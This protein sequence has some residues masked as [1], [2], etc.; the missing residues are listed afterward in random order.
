MTA[1]PKIVVSV[2]DP[3]LRDF[4]S[5]TDVNLRRLLEPAGGLFVAEGE[6]VILRALAEGFVPRSV[7]TEAKWW[8]GLKSAMTPHEPEVLLAEPELLRA[9]TGFEVHRGALA[10]FHRRPLPSL[11]EILESARRVVVMEGLVDHTNVGAIFRSAAALGADA[12]VVDPT[13]ADPLYRRSIKVSMGTVFAIP[14]TRDLTWPLGLAA[15]RAAGLRTVAMTPGGS[16]DIAEVGEQT[17]R[18]WALLIG[19]E[20]TGLTRQALDS[21]DLSVR[22]PMHAGVDSLNAAAAAAVA[23]YALGSGS[24]IARLIERGD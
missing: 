6:K 18:G 8:P 4:A 5:L 15:I 13:C 9:I 20:G 1:E 24:S 7:L 11:P 21:V 17:S 2:E 14:W 23:V 10:S 16:V 12:V 19:S 3:R 22:I